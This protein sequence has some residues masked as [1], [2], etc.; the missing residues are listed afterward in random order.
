MSK[1][2]IATEVWNTKQGT[3]VKAV[4]R[5]DKGIFL[6]ATNQTANISTPFALVGASR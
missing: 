3:V 1:I 4:A 2:I 6:G 5:T